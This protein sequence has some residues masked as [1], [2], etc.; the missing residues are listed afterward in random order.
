MITSEAYPPLILPL[1]GVVLPGGARD[2]SVTAEAEFNYAMR[3]AVA[4]SM[5]VGREGKSR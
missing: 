1:P 4:S 5:W 3:T 2:K